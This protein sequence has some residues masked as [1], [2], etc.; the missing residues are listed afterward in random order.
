MA[1]AEQSERWQPLASKYGAKMIAGGEHATREGVDSPRVAVVEF[2]SYEQATACYNDEDYQ[3]ILPVVKKA[4]GNT[5][6]LS[7]VKG[8]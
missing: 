8:V 4:Y 5:R 7:I 3:S 1:L 6:E 2:P